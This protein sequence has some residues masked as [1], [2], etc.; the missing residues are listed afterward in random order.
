MMCM[1]CSR[2]F[3]QQASTA[4]DTLGFCSARCE[5]KHT[6][7]VQ[8]ENSHTACIVDAFRNRICDLLEARRAS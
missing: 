6:F 3:D 5:F 1:E 8:S 4:R 7:P 2:D